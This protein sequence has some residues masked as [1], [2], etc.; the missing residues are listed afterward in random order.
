MG[1]RNKIGKNNVR[2]SHNKVSHNKHFSARNSSIN[3][4]STASTKVGRK[5]PEGGSKEFYRD[6]AKIKRIK[7]YN[8]ELKKKD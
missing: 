8:Q 4:N 2:K 5:I 7:M 1:K 6:N 3:K